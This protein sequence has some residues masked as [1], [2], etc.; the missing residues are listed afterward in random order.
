MD[1][2]LQN[3]LLN[4]RY[5]Y[6]NGGLNAKIN[7]NNSSRENATDYFKAATGA[8]SSNTSALSAISN[9]ENNRGYVTQDGGGFFGGL[10]GASSA[11]SGLRGK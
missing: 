8:Q 6:L 9:N 5:N 4:S 2:N 3:T 11:Y 10:L 7:L 1:M